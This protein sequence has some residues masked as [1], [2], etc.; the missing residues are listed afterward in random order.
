M[1]GSV[2]MTGATGFIGHEL[3][4]LFADWEVEHLV[5][6]PRR[7]GREVVWDFV[8]PVPEG[9]APCDVVVHL[10]ASVD[11]APEGRFA[12]YQSNV[13]S[14]LH[15]A[16]W[17]RLSNTPMLFAST[18]SIHGGLGVISPA[19]P[20]SPSSD[21]ALSKLLAEEIVRSHVGRNFIM[22]ISGVYGI[23]GPAH[24][25]LN[26]A[27]TRAVEDGVRPE[28]RGPG[29]GLRNYISVNDVARLLL[30]AAQEILTAPK[31][32]SRIEYAAGSEILSVKTLLQT[33]SDVVLDGQGPTR[34]PGDDCGDFV[35]E[36][37]WQPF[38]LTTFSEYLS[39][40]VAGRT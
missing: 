8:S 33:I 32:T 34:T 15:L 37:G 6:A 10:A 9:V 27:I 23:N 39:R 22:R 7:L 30:H 38:P 17:C 4:S 35:V 12:M 1:S 19:S 3:N 40:L 21:Y 5:R 18:A 20:A 36:G 31:G 13:L 11:Y 2:L 25:G 16:Q 26:A 14:T 24:M 29:N 28:L